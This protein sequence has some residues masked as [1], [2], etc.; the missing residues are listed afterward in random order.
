MWGTAPPGMPVWGM[1]LKAVILQEVTVQTLVIPSDLT[2][3]M[4]KKAA[5]VREHMQN[6]PIPPGLGLGFDP[7]EL[8]ATPPFQTPRRLAALLRPPEHKATAVLKPFKSL[9]LPPL[10]PTL[11]IR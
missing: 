11:R 4:V 1:R 5:A 8:G 10:F 2:P 7:E 6:Q 3:D 9:N